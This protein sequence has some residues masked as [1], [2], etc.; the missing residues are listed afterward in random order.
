MTQKGVIQKYK[1]GYLFGLIA[2][3]LIALSGCGSSS[4]ANQAAAAPPPPALPVLA[5]Q[6]LNVNTYKE[7]T[8]SVEGSKDIEIRPQVE[9]I[10]TKIYVD[11]GAYVHKGQTLFRIDSRPYNEQKNSA[12]ATLLAAK[13]A[14]QNAK[15]NVDKLLPLVKNNVVSDVQL[16][17]AQA[18]YEQAKA[19]VAQAQAAESSAS[20]NVGFTTIDAPADGYIGRI[21]Y[22]TGSLVGTTSPEAL[23]V[24]S[25]T[26][27][28]YVYF[29]MSETDFLHFTSSVQG[30][31]MEEKVSHIPPVSLVLA[32]DS[33]YPEKGKVEI[34]EGQ[35]DK[36]IGAISFRATFP[37][38]NGL[39]RSGN[40]GRIRVPDQAINGT[41]VPQEATFEVQNKTFVFVVGDSNKVASRQINIAQSAGTYY[42]VNNGVKA[43]DKIVYAGFDRLADGA[44]IQPQPITLDSLLK[45][46]PL[47]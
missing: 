29:S 10:L 46:S 33:L 30:K 19:N 15:I 37:N 2:F 47:E 3:S 5:L 28:M 38:A 27:Q 11:E 32:N 9:G 43:N 14:L 34:V 41:V 24:L 4:A 35:F 17:T 7:F 42:V 25:Q 39:L 16:Q 6:N 21:P 40:T 8:A 45:V 1:Y 44:A 22:K 20:I 23:T 13:A 26:K 18:Q 36:N 31:T 12:H